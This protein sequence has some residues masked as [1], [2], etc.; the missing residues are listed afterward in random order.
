VTD[1]SDQFLERLNRGPAALL[2]GQAHLRLGGSL[3][4]FL[5]AISRK[6]SVDSLTTLSYS[7]LFTP[8]ASVDPALQEWLDAKSRTFATSPQLDVIAQYAWIGVWC[9]AIDTLWAEAF[10]NS[11]REVQKVFSENFHSP[12]PRN[13]KRL[14]C[15]FLFGSIS[16][17]ESDERAP[18]SRL[19]YLRRRGR[20]QTLANRIPPVLGPTGTLAIDGYSPYD[21]FSPEDL[22]DVV[23]QMQPGQCHLFTATEDL[24]AIPEIQELVMHGLLVPHEKS[25][26]TILA[27]GNRAGVVALGTRAEE[28][29]LQRLVPFQEGTRSVPRD[30]WVTLSSSAHLLDEAVLADPWPLSGDAKYSEFRRFLGNSEGRPDW[31]GIAR[32]FTFR[33]DFETAL[34]RRVIEYATRRELHDHPIVL[35]GA[36]GTGKTIALSSLAFRLAKQRTYPVIYIDRRT[37]RFDR[38]AVDRFC[39]WAE[40]QGAPASIVIWDGMNNDL[41]TYEELARYFAGRGRRV[42]LVVSS[43]RIMGTQ[44]TRAANVV[45]AQDELTKGE[46]SRLDQFLG[47]FDNSLKTLTRFGMASDS[48]FFAFLYRLLPPTRAAMRGGLVR[49]LE[50]VERTLAERSAS[51]QG[52][53]E[54]RTAMGW[55]LLK[56]GLLPDIGYDQAESIEIAGEEF[57]AAEDL[58]SL[59]MVPAQFGLAIPLELLLRATG[60]D[61]YTGLPKLLA[62][63]DLVRWVEDRAGNFLLT[64]RSSLEAQII[65]RS[66][67]GTAGAEAEYASRLLVEVKDRDIALS[68]PAEVGFAV[69][70]VRAFAAEGPAAGRYRPEYRT[71]ATALRELR[72]ERGQAIPRLMLQEAH[73]LREW[74][75]RQADDDRESKLRALV[76]ASN[77]LLT[78]LQSEPSASLRSSLNVEL[79]S[80][81]GAHAQ[82]LSMVPDAVDERIHL[83]SEARAAALQARAVEAS[84]HPVDVL[85]WT[86]MDL[87]HDGILDEAERAEAIADVLSAFEL[88]DPQELD[89]SQLERYHRRR[90]QFAE[91]VGD[92]HLAEDAFE[93]LAS[94]GSG[95][96]VYLR[97]RAIADPAVIPQPMS[98]RDALNVEAALEYLAQYRDLVL[99]DVRCLNLQLDLWWILHAKQHPFADERYCVPLNTSEWRQAHTM[100]LELEGTGRTYREVPL[101]FLRGLAEFHLGDYTSAFDTFS[102][103]EHRSDEVSGRRRIVRSYLASTA[104]GRPV[105]YSGTVVWVSDDLRRGE[106][107]VDELRRRVSF[108]PREFGSREL[109][110][111]MGVNDFHIGFNFLGVIADPAGYLPTHRPGNL[112]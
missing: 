68:G 99:N 98:A 40:D 6:L 106:I 34:E 37:E 21:W 103:V 18:L 20:S 12:D 11:W 102:E 8:T 32:G 5:A 35:H 110:H 91:S 94:Q 9:S 38:R 96:G 72:E 56:A 28:G 2:L 69:N 49:E 79:A 13:R 22:V 71:L 31:E 15:T 54:P 78:A 10:E 89:S 61:G 62:D 33:R 97:A 93:A 66:R 101:L 95:A 107:F 92:V 82:A 36:T 85:T 41:A 30:I 81:F 3:D 90:Q 104:G 25:L 58:T 105:V 50:R 100:I 53:Y 70:L 60:Q 57:S 44:T 55:A 52:E 17:V 29:D 77:I 24:L 84:Y 39:Q 51:T 64:A 45:L 86:T 47:Q 67:L 73:L 109:T 46:V 4:P 80:T 1:M 26:A 75:M 59:I 112:R 48:T 16:R 42:V 19:D 43:Y 23:A 83:F 27:E 14:H 65:V 108:I 74:A 87:I 88:I 63:I 111:G 76:D 7:I